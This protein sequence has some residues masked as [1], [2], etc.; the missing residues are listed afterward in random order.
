MRKT[1]NLLPGAN[2]L[3]ALLGNRESHF[4]TKWP[5]QDLAADIAALFGL[6]L[7]DC[8]VDALQL[9]AGNHDLSTLL[10]HSGPFTAF[11]RADDSE[12]WEQ[13]TSADLDWNTVPDEG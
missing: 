7:D 6:T 4:V 12:F 5:F 9:V 8:G 13:F 3:P 1:G 11:F 10:P 2:D